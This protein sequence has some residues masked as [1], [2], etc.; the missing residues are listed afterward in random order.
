MF[1]RCTVYE[2]WF[3][4]LCRFL[5]IKHFV[6]LC[7]RICTVWKKLVIKTLVL[8]PQ[9]ALY[10]HNLFLVLNMIWYTIQTKMYVKMIRYSWKIIETINTSIFYL[11]LK[12]NNEIDLA[13]HAFISANSQ[14]ISSGSCWASADTRLAEQNLLLTALN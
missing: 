8:G 9:E 6:M 3:N 10:R 1:T 2:I 13:A 11:K 7:V 12:V 14:A 4:S 5:S